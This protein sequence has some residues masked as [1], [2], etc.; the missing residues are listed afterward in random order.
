[1]PGL[2]LHDTPVDNHAHQRTAQHRCNHDTWACP[3]AKT[4]TPGRTHYAIRRC[5]SACIHPASQPASQNKDFFHFPYR[6][7]NWFPSSICI[8]YEFYGLF[9]IDMRVSHVISL[10]QL[11]LDSFTIQAFQ[12]MLLIHSDLHYKLE[13]NE[14]IY[15]HVWEPVHYGCVCSSR[16]RCTVCWSWV[17]HSEPSCP[18]SDLLGVWNAQPVHFR[19]FYVDLEEF[20]Q[21][22]SFFL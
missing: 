1:M 2:I 13:Q 10:S 7:E 17:G 4:N 16:A 21:T 9:V 18:T 8:G 12:Q 3:T 15:I 11:Q 19:S 20:L 22:L 6:L 5:T 14:S